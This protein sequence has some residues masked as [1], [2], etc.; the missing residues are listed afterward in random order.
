MKALL[1]GTIILIEAALV[2]VVL[3][4]AAVFIQLAR[5][6]LTLDPLV[7]YVETALGQLAPDYSFR[8]AAAEL[9]WQGRTRRPDLTVKN[10]QVR[11]AAGE[12][13]AAFAAM[14]VSLDIPRLLRGQMV[15]E[16]LGITSPVV[17]VVRRM[18]GSIR[19]GL[20]ASVGALSQAVPS[21]EPSVGGEDRAAA[22]AA[23]LVGALRAPTT[24]IAA[25]DMRPSLESVDI[26]G[27]TVVL[28][29]EPSAQQWIAPDA[30]LRLLGQ[31][32]T[33]EIAATLPIVGSGATLTVD[34]AGRYTYAAGL[35]SLTASFDGV[36]PAAF[37]GLGEALAPMRAI[38]APLKGSVEVNL[39]PD[40]LRSQVAWGRLDLTIGAGALALPPEWGGTVAVL[41]GEL[42]AA[43]SGGLDQIAVENVSVRI[44]REGPGEPVPTISAAARAV[45]LRSAPDIDIQAR[46][47]A[48]SVQALKELWPDAVAPNTKS[49]IVRNLFEGTLSNVT[50]SI[51]LAGQA[52][53]AARPES[54]AL[55]AD[56]SGFD[57][58]YIAGMPQVENTK[59]VINVG[60]D[61]VT[62]AVSDGLVPDA[63]SRQGLRVGPALLRMTGLRTDRQMADF[64]IKVKGDLGEALRLIDH[65]PLKYARAMEVDPTRASGA[66]D[67]DLSLDFPLISDL[68]LDEVKIGVKAQVA[69]ARIED[70]VFGMPLSEGALALTVENDGLAVT[71]TAKIGAIRAGL[72]WTQDFTGAELR[73]E[74]ALDAIIENSDRAAIQLGFAPFIPP[75]IDG[76]IRAEVVY[77]S[78]RDGTSTLTAEGD[79]TQADM[80]IAELGWSKPAGTQGRF[81]ATV[82]LAQGRLTAVPAF[83]VTAADGFA[84]EG[85]A[86]FGDAAVLQSLELSRAQAGKT[87]LAA[88]VTRREQGGFAVDATGKFFDAS[89]YWKEL[90]KDESRDQDETET[91]PERDQ[92]PIVLTAAV[93]EMKLSR[94]GV[95]KNV[96]LSFERDTRAIRKVDLTSTL[97][98]GAPFTLKLE[99]QGAERAFTGASSDGGAVLRTIGLFDDI[100]GGKLTLD[101]KLTPAGVVEGQAEISEFQLVDAPLLARLLSVA[102]LTGIVDELRGE[103]ISFRTLRVPFGYASSTLRISDAEMFGSS[104]GLT[105]QG[106]YRFTDSVIDMNGTLIPAYALNAALNSIPIVGTLLT[107]TEKGGGIFAATFNWQGAAATAQPTVNPLAVLAPGILRRIF[108]IFGSSAPEA[109]QAAPSGQTQQR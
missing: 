41:G 75:N 29:D 100:V 95:F 30:S 45:N 78:M 18:D 82:A 56:L 55:R 81:E 101:G 64:D 36:R 7:P 40:N 37:A 96:A 21:S 91:Q 17:R 69:D 14:D 105:A 94:G 19:L 73:S 51:G 71:G 1:R 23:L 60:L 83:S 62:I 12:V 65:E 74:Y 10:V 85:A 68:S 2:A 5:G 49:W 76:P 34:V 20:E 79:L 47:D 107:G 33:M 86:T 50:A 25:G 31:S 103:G 72:T 4:G 61:E 39:I 87:D 53:F 46:I 16:H 9:S 58:N 48:L 70:V 26:T 8:I 93:D 57:V 3:I 59:G 24:D 88:K 35:L 67:V 80:R 66:T 89:Y 102:A 97:D 52:A 108:S 38:D 84:V 98:T 54:L 43:M 13:I 90:G 63:V 77:R 11:T 92:T 32:E 27:S 42:K 6:P 106:S 15:V 28:V 99:S 44:A 109:A 22:L 104:L